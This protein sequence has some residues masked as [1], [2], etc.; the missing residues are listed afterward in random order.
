MK[1]FLMAFLCL[2]PLLGLYAQE[3]QDSIHQQAR[4]V[5]NVRRSPAVSIESPC[6]VD[7]EKSDEEA[8]EILSVNG[9]KV[10]KLS[11]GIFIKRCFVFRWSGNV[12]KVTVKLINP[13]KIRIDFL[14]LNS[15]MLMNG[16][17][18][19]ILSYKWFYEPN[20]RLRYHKARSK[21]FA[22]II[23]LDKKSLTIFRNKDKQLHP[24][25]DE[26]YYFSGC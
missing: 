25:K 11:K 3:Q 19:D 26:L 8:L 24:L 12:G 6:F 23:D 13:K 9:F 5:P 15:D 1:N 17:E 14:E 21:S 2:S 20:G 10:W 16:V 7:F 18:G 22:G 4:V